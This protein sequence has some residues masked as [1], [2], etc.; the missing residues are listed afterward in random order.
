[1]VEV[2]DGTHTY[3]FG[4]V[5]RV[6]VLAPAGTV[7]RELNAYVEGSAAYFHLRCAVHARSEARVG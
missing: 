7:P 5:H 6:L 2:P 1:M 3:L 4:C